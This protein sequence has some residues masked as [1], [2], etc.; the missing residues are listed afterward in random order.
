MTPIIA[1][2]LSALL[3]VAGVVVYL[4]VRAPEAHEND[5]GFHF[6]ESNVEEIS[7]LNRTRG[8]SS[9]VLGSRASSVTHESERIS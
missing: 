8:V 2:I 6:G 7:P 9:V 1:A 5:T 4:V 3:V